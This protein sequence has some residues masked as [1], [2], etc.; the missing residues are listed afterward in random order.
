MV[1]ESQ[2]QLNWNQMRLMNSTA[3]A[4]TKNVQN[5]QCKW[6]PFAF[7][8]HKMQKNVKCAKYDSEWSLKTDVYSMQMVFFF[9]V[10]FICW[11]I[12]PFS[13]ELSSIF[14]WM[15]N[16]N[17]MNREHIKI[18][19]IKKIRIEEKEIPRKF[20]HFCLLQTRK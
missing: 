13:T 1:D 9:D 15:P 4:V 11:K 12:N 5:F 8:Q 10:K 19:S 18:I 20:H 16:K 6:H 14:I 7:K 17:R 2:S 3:S